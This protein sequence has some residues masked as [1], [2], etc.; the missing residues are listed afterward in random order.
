VSDSVN[1]PSLANTPFHAKIE[2]KM[3]VYAIGDVHGRGDL[4]QR[5]LARIDAYT[6]AHPTP[7]PVLVFLGDYIDRGPSSREVIDQ[8]V[9]L[10]KEWEVV[11]LEGNHEYYLMKFLKNPPFLPDWLRYGGL[12]TLR[13]YGIFP[14]NYLELGEQEIL[15]ASLNLILLE[16]GHHNFLSSLRRSFVCGDFF[17]VHAGVRPGVPLDQQSQRDLLEIRNDFLSSASDF[18]K[19][20]VHG[21]TPVT[22][23]DIRLNRINID[24]G[25]YATGKLSCIII[26]RDEIR[27]F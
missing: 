17:F 2:D 14:K 3:R 5:M 6:S 22:Q 24:T 11:F 4:L 15:A 25:A 1:L 10:N 7:R 9:L 8:L 18:G 27:F 19:I 12:D 16:N 13:S 21:H 20:V 26:E 23:P